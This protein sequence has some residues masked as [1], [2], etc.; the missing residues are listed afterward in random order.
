MT[1][2]SSSSFENNI[3][4]FDRKFF[5]SEHLFTSIGSG[6]LGG[7]AKSLAIIHDFLSSS[8]ELLEYPEI[9][10]SIPRLTVIRT[11]VFDSFMA[12]NRLWDS[13]LSDEPDDRIAHVFQKAT[14]PIE[15]IGD[16]RA[17]VSHVHRPLA[18]RSSSLLEDAIYEPFAGIYGTKMIPNNQ[19][20]PDVR[21]QK[22]VEAI[23]FVFASTYFGAAKD[24]IRATEHD[25]REEKMAVIIQEVVGHRH[26]DRF[27]PEVSG[28]AKSYNFYASGRAKPDEGVISLALGLGKTIVDGGISWSYSPAHPR[29]GPP[30]GSTKEFLN[31]T[32]TEFWAVN[33]GKPPEYDP[34]RE[35]EYLTRVSIQLAEEDGVLKNLASTYDSASDR[36]TAGMHVSGPRILTFAPLLEWNVI[37]LNDLLKTLLLLSQNAFEVPTEIEFALTFQ[38]DKQSQTKNRLGFLQVRPMV[39]SREQ[40]VITEDDLDRP[41]LFTASDTVLGNGLVRGIKDV[42]FVKPEQFTASN[43]KAIAAEIASMN[44][45]LLSR[46]KPYLLIGFGRW[47][48]SDPWLGIPV[49]WGQ[50]SGAKAIVEA[51]LPNMNIELSQGS[52]FFQNLTSFK[53]S[54][55]SIPFTAEHPVDW[56][57][58]NQQEKALEKKFVCHSILKDPLLIKVDGRTGRGMILKKA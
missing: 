40:V 11:G 16:L 7:K 22:L 47:G 49:N 52:H 28:V 23:K 43:N 51:T 5:D 54:Y 24:Y 29:I 26:S 2:I 21:F 14:L 25:P 19:P 37:P 6:E 1:T 35:T 53:V 3:H 46:G 17:L 38:D 34:I 10:V 20:N 8:E 48:S 57:W 36:I 42:I 12:R 9:E 58:L 56:E 32:Q 33:M 39:V 27:Y 30:L 55:F 44:R 18:V 41:D 50:V 45:K 31:N 15:I 4:P 13:A